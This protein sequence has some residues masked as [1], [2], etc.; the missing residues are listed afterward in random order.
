M[1]VFEKCTSKP[2]NNSTSN[3][4]LLP[5]WMPSIG[6]QQPGDETGNILDFTRK[7]YR[8]LATANQLSLFDL[9][10]YLFA[11]QAHLLLRLDRLT[12][13][14]Q[15]A[16]QAINKFAMIPW[17]YERDH[18]PA[19]FRTRWSFCACLAVLSLCERVSSNVNDSSSIDRVVVQSTSASSAS[20]GTDRCEKI[21][22]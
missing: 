11:R 1:E 15:R 16:R 17:D 14:L 8:Q 7:P 5:S 22:N 18:L 19:L 3:M 12:D 6:G 9:N 13:L 10:I 2:L 21:I 20:S 4:E